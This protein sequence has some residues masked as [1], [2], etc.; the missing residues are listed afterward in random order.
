MYS[1]STRMSLCVRW[2]DG[3][4]AARLIAAMGSVFVPVLSPRRCRQISGTVY[5]KGLGSPPRSA[6]FAHA[7]CT[8]AAACVTCVE[9][10]SAKAAAVVVVNIPK[11]DTHGSSYLLYPH[12]MI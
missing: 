7:C 8:L 3:V 5:S 6:A 12:F 9:L 2:C 4:M 10:C 1:C 11:N